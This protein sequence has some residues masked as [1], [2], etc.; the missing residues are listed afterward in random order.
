MRKVLKSIL[1]ILQLLVVAIFVI[2]F[3]LAQRY[4]IKGIVMT[5]MKG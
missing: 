4:F 5:G 1:K 3:F 2:L